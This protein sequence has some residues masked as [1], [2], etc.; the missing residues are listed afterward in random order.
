ML[1][2]NFPDQPILFRNLGPWNNKR[3][4]RIDTDKDIMPGCNHTVHLIPRKRRTL[5]SLGSCPPG[6]INR[7]MQD[8]F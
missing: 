6:V 3:I 8:I 5:I 1:L 7:I 4:A 2:R